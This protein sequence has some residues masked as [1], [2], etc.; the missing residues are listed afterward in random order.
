M[1]EETP[2]TTDEAS[3][4]LGIDKQRG[5]RIALESGIAIPW[6]NGAKRQFVKVLFSEFRQAVLNQRPAPKVR[7]PAFRGLHHDV[8]C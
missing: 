8:R 6:G 1:N 3:R 7:R 5:R 2:I 4:K